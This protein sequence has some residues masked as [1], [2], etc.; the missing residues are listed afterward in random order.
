MQ[1]YSKAFLH[2][3]GGIK[4]HPAACKNALEYFCTQRNENSNLVRVINQRIHQLLALCT[5]SSS[6]SD[7]IF[8]RTLQVIDVKFDEL[9]EVREKEQITFLP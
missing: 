9:R 1:K 6:I 3:S 5:L 8:T 7:A 4:M 2:A